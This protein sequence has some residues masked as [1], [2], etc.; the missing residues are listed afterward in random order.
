VPFAPFF[1]RRASSRLRAPAF[2][3]SSSTARASASAAPRASPEAASAT[4]SA[5]CAPASPPWEARGGARQERRVGRAGR[6]GGVDGLARLLGLTRERERLGEGDLPGGAGPRAAATALLA[7]GHGFPGGGDGGRGLL[8]GLLGH[9]EGGVEIAREGRVVGKAL[10]AG[11]RGGARRAGISL[12]GLL[13]GGGEA[14]DDDARVGGEARREGVDQVER[15]GRHL[16]GAVLDA[17]EVE[18]RLAR[19]GLDELRV[20]LDRQARDLPEA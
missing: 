15:L 5:S 1:G 4:P 14:E 10:Q 20:L 13:A 3:G 11:E 12:P 2:S 18:E 19:A 6:K 16:P 8:S 9:G 17:D 7:E